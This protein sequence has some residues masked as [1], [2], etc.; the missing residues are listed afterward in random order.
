MAEKFPTGPDPEAES[1]GRKISGLFEAGSRLFSTRA[2][3][4]GEELS[5]KTTFLGKGC[6]GVSL[7]AAFVFL[8]LL[9]FTAFIAALFT[10]LLGGPVAGIAAAFGLHILIAGLIGWFGVRQLSRVKPTEF[11]VTGAEIR[12][13]IAAIKAAA[14]P[15][16]SPPPVSTEGKPVPTS[17]SPSPTPGPPVPAPPRARPTP[18]ADDLEARFRAGSE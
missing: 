10:S 17:A 7:A 1:L 16:P 15:P 2:S 8:A 5:V 14:C 12:K 6:A 11:P 18:T 4:F 3:L 9:L 13:D